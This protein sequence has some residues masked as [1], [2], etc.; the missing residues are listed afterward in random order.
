VFIKSA[1]VP[2]VVITQALLP[3]HLSRDNYVNKL[4]LS[5]FVT[6]TDNLSANQ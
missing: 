4:G 6:T 2:L 1:G 3:F 5:T